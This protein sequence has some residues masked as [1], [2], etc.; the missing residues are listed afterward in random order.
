MSKAGYI[1]FNREQKLFL[2]N[3]TLFEIII[4]NSM[5]GSIPLFMFKAIQIVANYFNTP[6]LLYS[7]LLIG[8]FSC[9]EVTSK[10]EFENAGGTFNYAISNEPAFLTPRNAT[11]FYS[12]TLLNQIF[13]GLVT[14]DPKTL[15]T[16]S[17]LA[18]D[19]SISEDGKT[20]RF[21]L[22]DD[23][24]FHEHP[25]LPG[26][27]K[28][29]PEDVIYSIELA[30]TP[31]NNEASSA[32]YSIYKGLLAGA[33]EFYNQESESI[34]GLSVRGNT[35]EMKLLQ[36]DVNFVDKLTQ[37]A[38]LIVSK[39][40]I[41]AGLENE[42]IGTGPFKFLEN[43]NQKERKEIFLIKNDAYYGK[44]DQ[45]YQL[46]YLDTLI[47]K[48]ESK[49]TEQLKMFKKE[50]IHLVE[51]LPP[52][53]ISSMLGKGKIE[54]FNT[55]PPKY[56]LTR[57]P[58]LATQYYY[59]NLMK[60]YFQDLKVRQAFNYA[61]DRNKIVSAILNNQAYSKG[62][63][64]I[65]PPAVFSGYNSK[66]VKQNGYTYQPQ[67]AKRLFAQAGYPDGKDFP[68]IDLKF[69]IGT[70]HSAVANEIA[71]Q[72]KHTL[73]VNVNLEGVPFQEKLKNQRYGNGDLFRTSWI[74]E[75][76]SPESFLMTAYGK[77]IPTDSLKPSMTNHSRY[78]NEAFNKAFDKAKGRTD[79][80]ER[81]KSFAEA[82]S[83]L[84]KDAPYIILWYEETIK[85]AYSK[86]RNLQL[87]V[88]NNYS[89]KKVY[90]KNW[91]ESEWEIKKEQ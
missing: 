39:K 81:Y 40:A 41:E 29:T 56:V 32:Y 63:G 82:E 52:S 46:P 22:R 36:R 9:S 71:N 50:E 70:I 7:L 66:K 84:M 34:S 62:D 58:L 85:I 83:I 72:L 88:M 80:V 17:E 10:E 59:F 57:K 64:G 77:T 87:N 3:S 2:S 37:T 45:G 75:Y 65:V 35:I 69:N 30:C 74:A 33:D 20:I 53:K 5:F 48:V 1:D 23:A 15:E 49:R 90:L 13:E 78:Q 68:T 8:F 43:R 16:K 55:T 76:Y 42:L 14:L 4:L 26:E 44:D 51:G 47:L 11:D 91:T 38:A 19:W 21:E 89:F 28:L 31:Y 54:E 18:K 60:P 61:V 12:S 73:N 79:I 25:S 67:K 27:N 86:V 24:Y 6:T